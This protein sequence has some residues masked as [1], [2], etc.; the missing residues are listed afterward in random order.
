M[1]EVKEKELATYRKYVDTFT[2]GLSAEGAL[3]FNQG[4][5]SEMSKS[6][7]I[8]LKSLKESTLKMIETEEKLEALTKRRDAL[9]F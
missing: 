3:K 9:G 5:E 6:D 8:T 2:H 7:Q 4:K 1:I